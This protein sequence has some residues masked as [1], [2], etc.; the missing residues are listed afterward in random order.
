MNTAERKLAVAIARCDHLGEAAGDTSHPCHKVVSFQNDGPDRHIPE[1]WYGNLSS[2]RVLFLASN[3]SIDLSDGH[4]GENYPRAHWDDDLISEWITRRVDQSWSEVPVTFGQTQQKN[5]LWRCRDGEYR[6]AGP[7]NK[8]QP[9]WNNT[10]KLAMELLGNVADPSANYALTEVVHCKSTNG[11]GVKEAE[12]MCSG[13]W[14]PSILNQAAQV[15]VIVMLGSHVRSWALQAYKDLVPDDFGSRVARGGQHVA[16]RD[17]FVTVND[18][19]RPI[20]YCYLPHPTA[21]EPG[22]RTFS[23]RYGA[24]ITKVLGQIAQGS[25]PIPTTTRE[26]RGLFE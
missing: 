25:L 26:L 2:A 7:S 20:V 11:H 14:L 4:D 24:D 21:S 18:A 5:F 3:P 19:K 8:P 23:T 10:H 13:K 17:S 15:S 12:S 22:G 9:T 16:R 1:A 6:G